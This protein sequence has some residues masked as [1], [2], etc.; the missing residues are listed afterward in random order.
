MVRQVPDAIDEEF[1]G[2]GVRPAGLDHPATQLHQLMGGKNEIY[3]MLDV[4]RFN[5]RMVE[6]KKN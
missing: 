4:T 2:V 3:C 1:I 5:V 6:E